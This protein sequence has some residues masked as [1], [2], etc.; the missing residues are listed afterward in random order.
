MEKFPVYSIVLQNL[1]VSLE[2]WLKP[3]FTG[4]STKCD[5]KYAWYYYA[6]NQKCYMHDFR[7]ILLDCVTY[8]DG[9]NLAGLDQ[10]VA[11]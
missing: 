1:L 6:G 2:P 7:L 8:D 11:F 5:I 4:F 10:N 3:I 9:V